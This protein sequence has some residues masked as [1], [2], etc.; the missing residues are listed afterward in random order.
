MKAAIPTLWLTGLSGAGKS[1]LAHALSTHAYFGERRV[2]VLDG[3]VMRAGLC[4]DLGFSAADRHENVRRIA[5]VA[6]LLNG[7]GVHVIC[8]LISPLHADRALARSIV[9]VDRFIEVHVATSL[10]ACEARDPKGLYKRARAGQIAEFT[11]ISSAYE[12]PLDPTLTLNTAELPLD[13]CVERMLDELRA[14]A[15]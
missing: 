12:T 14:R 4:S 8:A 1:T 9:G 15:G 3:D 6:K 2:A 5:E 13:V 7:A 11:G 10:E